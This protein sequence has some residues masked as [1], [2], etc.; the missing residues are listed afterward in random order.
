MSTYHNIE[1]EQ[2]ASSRADPP[3]SDEQDF[4]AQTPPQPP[5]KPPHPGSNRP[6][7]VIAVVLALALVLSLS[8]IF[9][10]GLISHPGGQVTPT[11]TSPSSRVTPTT[12]PTT[13]V[14]LTQR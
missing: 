2:K 6:I 5:Q 3:A 4:S 1:N 11:P 9:L 10:P 8:L 14:T 12:V 13:P 7:V